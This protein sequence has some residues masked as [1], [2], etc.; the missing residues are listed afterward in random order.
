MK[1]IFCLILSMLMA[2]VCLTS[3]KDEGDSGKISLI[4]SN[5]YGVITPIDIYKIKDGYI[6]FLQS[7]KIIEVK[8]KYNYCVYYYCKNKKQKFY[9]KRFL[10]IDKATYKITFWD[11]RDDQPADGFTYEKDLIYF[12][13]YFGKKENLSIVANVSFYETFYIK[14]EERDDTYKITYYDDP[15]IYNNFNDPIVFNDIKMLDDYKR[16]IE[17]P[18]SDITKIE[19]IV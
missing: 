18:K 10:N 8:K 1:K 7:D 13:E 17:V 9:G 4:V 11:S 14:L 16:V 12:S 2:G 5:M 19:Y 3:C 6:D 15:V